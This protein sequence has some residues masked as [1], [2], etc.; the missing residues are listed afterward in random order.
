MITPQKI[1]ELELKAEAI[2]ETIVQMLLAAG[3]GHTAGPL[4]LADIFAAFYFYILTHDP[5]NP[6]WQ[7]RDR[8]ILSN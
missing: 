8:L 4:G 6:Q 7:E 3:S 5:K 1:K 2:R